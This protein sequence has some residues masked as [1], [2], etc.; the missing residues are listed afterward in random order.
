MTNEM[1]FS[2]NNHLIQVIRN[3][4]LIQVKMNGTEYFRKTLSSNGQLDAQVLYLG[5]PPPAADGSDANLTEEEKDRLYFKGIIQDVQVSN[6]I[7]SMS[8]E[9]YPLN[10]TEG[11]ELPKPFGKVSI[12]QG[13]VLRGE[14]SD[15]LCRKKPCQ[16]NAECKN[17]WN[18]FECTCPKGYKGKFCQDIEFCQ[19]NKCPGNGVCQ[20]LDDGFECI[21]NVTF[22]GNEKTP[23]SFAYFNKNQEEEVKLPTVIEIS[24]RSKTGG[25]LFYI[26]DEDN[27]FEIA[28]F[29]DQVTVQWRLGNVDY[30]TTR[31]FNKENTKFDWSTIYLRVHNGKLECGF[32]GWEDQSDIP[33]AFTEHLNE[34]GIF[35]D[36]ISGKHPIFLGGM[37]L[38]DNLLSKTQNSGAIFKGCLGEVRVGHKLLP[39]FLYNEMYLD[40]VQLRSQ[41]KLNGPKVDEGC[42]LC[43]QEDCQ[44]GG[45]CTN[46][47]EQYACTCKPGFEGDDC[48]IDIDECLTA[49]CTNNS[50]CIDEIAGFTCK[51]LPGYDGTLCEHEIDECSSNPC[52]NGG[53]CTD[54]IAAFKCDCTEE[55]AGAQCDVLKLVTCETVPNPC[56]KGSSCVDGFSKLSLVPL[57]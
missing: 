39:F 54:L 49:E 33:S 14:V 26:Q 35:Q 42:V 16:H 47:S 23:L 20:N 19:L 29:K 36:F 52:H 5:G 56:K 1:S 50:T 37:P 4:T 55:Y 51:C 7:Q 57:I 13:S 43:F 38:G 18:D 25:T 41:F 10:K 45:K 28:V 11:L 3:Q 30:P 17:T 15:D 24:Y 6:G 31:R 21:T 27:Y 34:E 2:R 48:S 44:N 53:V 8:V 22:K 9:L 40:S 46:S 12:D 32:K